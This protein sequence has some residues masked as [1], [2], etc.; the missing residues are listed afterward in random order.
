MKIDLHCHSKEYSPCSPISAELMIEGAIK[1]GLDAI[2]FTNHDMFVE[3]Q[4]LSRL[5]EQ[6]P[7]IKIFNAI[8]VSVGLE[9]IVCIGVIDK[10]LE[11]W[12]GTYEALHK[13]MRKN[14]GFMIW[15]HPIRFTRPQINLA[16]YPPDALEIHSS[17][18][19]ADDF[20]EI[21]AIAEKYKLKMLANSDAHSPELTGIYHNIIDSNPA[22]E[23]EL[24]E[25]LR[26]N[27]IAWQ[28]DNLRIS[29]WNKAMEKSED[30]I[31]K[32]ICN[33]GTALEYE[34][35][36][37]RWSGYYEKVKAGKSYKI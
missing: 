2:A 3:E 7:A 1:Y 19:G 29:K 34:Q 5:R 24:A 14:H 32:F 6:Y 30:I 15:A 9:H 16:K 8:E 27:F 11:G 23:T 21:S 4:H 22:N 28:G 25:A 10:A 17:N 20:E 37:K 13:Y 31:R 35:K 12:K 26:N 33:G 36:Y 18:T